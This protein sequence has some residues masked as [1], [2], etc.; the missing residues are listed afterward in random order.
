[1]TTPRPRTVVYGVVCMAVSLVIGCYILAFQWKEVEVGLFSFLIV[2]SLTAC[3]WFWGWARWVI[4]F[5]AVSSV[6]ATWSIV[7]FQL[8]FRILMPVLTYTQFALELTGFA[9]LFHPASAR[10]YR[11][12]RMADPGAPPRG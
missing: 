2:G 12:K 6:W 3:A 4:A 7:S 8:T 10:W 5:L 1:M 11:R 9:L